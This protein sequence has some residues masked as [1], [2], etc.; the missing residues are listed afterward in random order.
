MS[1]LNVVDII[2]V[3]TKVKGPRTQAP[4]LGENPSEL[5]PDAQQAK[6]FALGAQFVIIQG[7]CQ[8]DLRF[9]VA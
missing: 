2:T 3:T 9:K 5:V 8:Q 7:L 6:F 4:T 1:Y